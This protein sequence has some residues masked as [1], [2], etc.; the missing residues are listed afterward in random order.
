MDIVTLITMLLIGVF[1]GLVS[2]MVGIG[3]AI[4][5]YPAILIIPS[6]L[7]LHTYTPYL[8][9]GLASSQ[10]FFSTLSGS[11][12]AKSNPEF[13]LKLVLY[14]GASTLIGSTVGAFFTQWFST[15]AVN[16]VYIVV[17]ILALVLL[18]I[19]VKPQEGKPHLN[20]MLLILFGIGI[21]AISG[22]VGAGG[23]FMI[24]PVLLVFFKLPMN[25]V[26]ANSIVIAFISSIGSFVIKLF[27]GFIPIADAIPLVIGSIIFAP[28]GLMIGK[29]LP[30]V[31][32]KWI[33][34]I[35]III[36]VIQLIF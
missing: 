25:T 11:I 35:L 2:G 9:S 27:Q 34:S 33:I 24:I 31:V 20:R 3:G 12:K 32:Q 14:M 29:K 6:L 36:A 17:A 15:T 4:I 13:S 7:G 23:S 1:G 22:I 10:V 21:G 18:F 19:K 28:I 16:I 8:A 30:S 5:I 26:V